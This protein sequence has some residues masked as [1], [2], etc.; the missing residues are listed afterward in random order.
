MLEESPLTLPQLVVTIYCG[1]EY[2]HEASRHD[3]TTQIANFILNNFFVFHFSVFSFKLQPKLTIVE[4][5]ILFIF[6]QKN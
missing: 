2:A 1:S 4:E 6:I 3:K 5:L